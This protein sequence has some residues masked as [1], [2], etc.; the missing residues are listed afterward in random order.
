MT[1]QVEHPVDLRDGHAFRAISDL[2][3]L[4]ASCHLALL[5]HAQVKARFPV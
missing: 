2:Y 1:G 3:D 4:V 5:Q